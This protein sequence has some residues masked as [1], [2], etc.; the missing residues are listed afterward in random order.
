MVVGGGN[1]TATA[2]AAAASPSTVCATCIVNFCDALEGTDVGCSRL[3]SEASGNPL[4]TPENNS[5]ILLY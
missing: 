4:L 5:L 3:D 2:A 1:D